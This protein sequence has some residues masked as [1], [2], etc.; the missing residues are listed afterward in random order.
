VHLISDTFD[1]GRVEKCLGDVS[2][3]PL[4]V[5]LNEIAESCDDHLVC[6]RSMCLSL[7]THRARIPDMTIGNQFLNIDRI[8]NNILRCSSL[9]MSDCGLL[10]ELGRGSALSVST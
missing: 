1:K 3:T 10:L 5:V 6:V 2:E 4:V 7:R 9:V 8:L